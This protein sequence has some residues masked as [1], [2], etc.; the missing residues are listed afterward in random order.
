MKLFLVL[1]LSF[2]ATAYSMPIS[3]EIAVKCLI[4]EAGNQGFEG[5]Q[6]VGE[7]LRLRGSIKGLY[8]C[9]NRVFSHSSPKLRKQALSAWKASKT[10]NLTKKATH[11]ENIEVFGEPY[12]AKGMTKTVKIKDHTFLK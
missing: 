3:E 4:G 12:W 2:Q 8:G 9:K 1:F 11:F 10:S 7:V 5:M 6:A